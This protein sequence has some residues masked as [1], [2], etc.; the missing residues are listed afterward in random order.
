MRFAGSG[1]RVVEVAV[2]HVSI[3]DRIFFNKAPGSAPSGAAQAG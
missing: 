2:S 1:N 3:G